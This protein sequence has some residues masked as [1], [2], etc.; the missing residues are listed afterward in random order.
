[1]GGK[2]L[3]SGDPPAPPETE[4]NRFSFRHSLNFPVHFDTSMN[5]MGKNCQVRCQQLDL[6]V[7]R[8]TRADAE[9]VLFFPKS[10]KGLTILASR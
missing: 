1:M 7:V 2:V 4:D 8:I 10:P 3:M 6:L 9:T 5:S